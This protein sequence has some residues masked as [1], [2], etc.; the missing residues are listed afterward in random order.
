MLP[1]Q[2]RPH[3]GKRHAVLQLIAKAVCAAGLIKG[4]P[5]PDAAGERLIQHPAIED[6]IQRPVRRFHLDRAENMLPMLRDLTEDGVEIG[7]AVASEQRPRGRC[8]V[9]F[10]EEENDLHVW[11][12]SRSTNVRSAQHG[13][14]PAPA[15]L[16]SGT[17]A[18]MAAGISRVPWRPRNSPRSAVHCD[19]RPGEIRKSDSRAEGGIPRIAGEQGARVRIELGQNEGRRRP[20]R[21]A[22]HPF[23][24]SRDRQPSRAPRGVA[25]PQA[26]DL[27]GIAH[28]HEHAKIQ[29]EVARGKLESA[30]SLSVP[31]GIGRTR[32]AD[33]RGRR[34]PHLAGLLIAQI[35]HLAG[36]I[37]DRIVRPRGDLMFPAVEG[38]GE[39][40][41]VGRNLKSKVRIGDHVDPWRGGRL[42]RSQMS[43]VFVALG[44]E[45]S[46][47]IE[48]FEIVARVAARG[49]LGRRRTL[50]GQRGESRRACAR[51]RVDP[52]ARRAAQPGRLA[53]RPAGVCASD[54]R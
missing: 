4:C 38:P 48:E 27:D 39:A 5:R 20:A 47:A 31:R 50:H 8:V 30:V 52:R 16:A 24:V 43:H 53:Q 25:N 42:S 45:P 7:V 29:L 49:G 44:S 2:I 40:A 51:D 3:D 22:E 17:R 26:G 34:P 41:A 54:R 28:G 9:G 36:T 46:Q 1:G 18:A 37:R 15:R 19:C 6:D 21:S 13:S 14:R 23:R 32:V 10:A 11:P 12:G 33:R 35:Q